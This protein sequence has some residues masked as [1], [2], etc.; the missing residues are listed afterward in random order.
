MRNRPSDHIEQYVFNVKT[1]VTIEINPADIY[2]I[3]TIKVVQTESCMPKFCCG[4]NRNIVFLFQVHDKFPL[5]ARRILDRPPESRTDDDC[6][7]LHALLR[8]MRSWDKFTE[9]IQ[10]AMCRAFSY[11]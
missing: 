2:V 1:F 11:E 4:P 10:L 9:R 3:R 8:G 5:W 6:K 7:R